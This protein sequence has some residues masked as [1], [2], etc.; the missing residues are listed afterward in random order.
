MFSA[1][2]IEA[3]TGPEVSIFKKFKT[4]W[5][6]MNKK[7]FSSGI[8]DPFVQVA[9]ADTSADILSFCRN[10]IN[11]KFRELLELVII[12]LGGKLVKE[13]KF[14]RPSAFHHARWMAK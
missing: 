5:E 2:K 4:E 11:E 13:V 9:T 3:S 14:Y 1:N 12:F 7:N 10:V 8:V 6:H